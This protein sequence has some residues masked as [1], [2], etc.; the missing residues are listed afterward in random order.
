VEAAG[1]S[2]QTLG[3]FDDH[4][5]VCIFFAVHAAK[6]TGGESINVLLPENRP[7]QQQQPTSKPENKVVFFMS[8]RLF[9]WNI[10]MNN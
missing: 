9:K 1:A 8:P 6:G 4:P 3:I 2:G 10:K 7:R 5:A